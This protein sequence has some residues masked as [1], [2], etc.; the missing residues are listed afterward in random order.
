MTNAVSGEK[1]NVE[2]IVYNGTAKN[3][4]AYND[5]ATAP[6]E[7]SEGK[8][9][10][11]A[12]KLSDENYTVKGTAAHKFSVA[13][14]EVSITYDLSKSPYTYDAASHIPAWEVVGL[15]EGDT[16][17]VSDYTLSGK[18]VFD[19]D[20]SKATGAVNATKD[21]SAVIVTVTAIGNGNYKLPTSA[22]CK[23]E[24]KIVPLNLEDLKVGT[25]DNHAAEA[26]SNIW[27]AKMGYTG[28][29]Q[30]P[31][32]M[33]DSAAGEKE[34][35]NEKPNRTKYESYQDEQKN[36]LV[37]GYNASSQTEALSYSNKTLSIDDKLKG[38]EIEITGINN[39]KGTTKIPWNIDILESSIEI[40]NYEAAGTKP[41]TVTYGETLPEIEFSYK[42]EDIEKDSEKE[43]EDYVTYT[44]TGTMKN[45]KKYGE[46][47]EEKHT[48]PVE[49]GEYEVTATLAATDH[50]KEVAAT[51]KFIIA[52]KEVTIRSGVAVYDKEYDGTDE[53]QLNFTGFDDDSWEGLLDKD[54]ET[55]KT[56]LANVA[57]GDKGYITYTAKFAE[58]SSTNT[59]AKDV[60]WG[61]N[62]SYQKVVED[63]TVEISGYAIDYSKEDTPDVLYNYVIANNGNPATGKAKITPKQISVSG[64]TAKD[65]VY[66]GSRDVELIIP[67]SEKMIKGLVG[68]EKLSLN[69]TGKFADAPGVE[70]E[71]VVL[72]DGKPA[73]KEVT[74][75]Y[76]NDSIIAGDTSTKAAN[77]KLKVKTDTDGKIITDDKGNEVIDDTAVQ[78]TTNATITPATITI[79]GVKAAEKTYDGTPNVTLIWDD[80]SVSITGVCSG[81]VIELDN[82]VNNGTNGWTADSFNDAGVARNKYDEV[83]D[84]E[85]TITS[86]E[87]D[88]IAKNGL[89]GTFNPADYKVADISFT[90]KIN[91]KKISGITWSYDKDSFSDLAE[92][93]KLLC[94]TSYTVDKKNLEQ[95]PKAAFE[96]GSGVLAGDSCEPVVKYYTA[97][98][99]EFA[100]PLNEVEIQIEENSEKT[101]T[102][103]YTPLPYLEDNGKYVVKVVSTTNPNYVVD[104]TAS[105]ITKSFTY[106]SNADSSELAITNY[107]KE[108]NKSFTVTYGDPLPKVE[109]S[110]NNSDI[111]K[112]DAAAR[113]AH[114]TYRYTGKALNGENYDSDKAPVN[115]GS[116]EVTVALEA[117]EHFAASEDSAAFIIEPR[118]VTI[119]QGISVKDKIYN[120]TDKATLD[121][122]NI[123]FDNIIEA[124]KETVS[125]LFADAKEDYIRYSAQFPQKDVKYMETV[126]DDNGGTGRKIAEM[127]VTA[128]N[129]SFIQAETTP[130][131]LYN[132][133]IARE[134][135]IGSLYGKIKPRPVTV[136]GIRADDKTFDGTDNLSLN[137]SEMKF[138]GHIKGDALK[139][140]VKGKIA[141]T[142]GVPARDVLIGKD[143]KPGEKKVLLTI[144]DLTAG[145]NTTNVDNY[146]LADKGQQTET[147]VKI[148]PAELTSAKWSF[149]TGK[150][151]PTAVIDKDSGLITTGSA[152]TVQ[153]KYYEASDMSYKKPITV[154][155]LKAG[156][157]YV[158]RIEGYSDTNYQMSKKF[159]NPIYP[160][161][162]GKKTETAAEKK[163]VAKKKK[164]IINLKTVT[165]KKNQMKIRWT[166]VSSADGYDVYVKYCTS[167]S[168][169]IKPVKTVKNNRKTFVTVKKIN[170]KKLN[171][172]KN[173]TIYVR[174]YRKVG[175]KKKILAKS[176]SGHVAGYRNQKYSNV[177]KVTLLK[178]RYTIK[179]GK[180]ARIK[181][182][183]TLLKKNRKHLPK[184][185]GAR[186]RYKS[187]DTS[188]AT[189]NRS[190]RI[191]GVKK[192]TCT[193]YVY[194]I[195]GFAKKVRVTVK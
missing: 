26:G 59:A 93:A 43:P 23:A 163:T 86:A 129:Y 172:K 100:N 125:T 139:V 180:T 164:I 32:I 22:D 35:K 34:L 72:D 95:I 147:T 133:S 98:D 14:K 91:P 5:S 155:E 20:Y 190:G 42:N 41:Y 67:E 181:A 152:G 90:G 88:I 50:Y 68:K 63:K 1:V 184:S 166:R 24:Y 103:V 27:A 73:A 189:V 153:L 170:G 79:H 74:L 92:G 53:A 161:V 156:G 16:C 66:N 111:E 33:W 82:T 183:V 84:K 151:L 162:Y 60:K 101:R 128:G 17:E 36:A 65:K 167:K 188:I 191:K 165:Q 119:L 40:T 144:S 195:N 150:N 48:A 157:S 109:L 137:L 114:F 38:Y 44:Y 15:V 138:T 28:A 113:A 4:T 104:E 76:D 75:I 81:D 130:A 96:S 64:I 25:W 122:R 175:G 179:T 193:I 106:D 12:T 69:I 10:V 83:I 30:E 71:D 176:V 105:D 80:Q 58:D 116:Y 37:R 149:D 99:K 31:K 115:A 194:S 177:K 146:Y 160:F 131:V 185:H 159:R 182:K 6:K 154:K 168:S 61:R 117:T 134:N 97:A 124:D 2:E 78:Q 169:H 85:G 47:E 54:K 102:G 127:S 108:N 62:A 174:A 52:Q 49:A 77:Y 3:G 118:S 173:F 187:S 45:G 9:S 87:Y 145:D 148:T 140:S 135:T 120:G 94:S 121:F 89:K 56:A 110:Y 186:F 7:A 107:Q 55:V 123:V 136:S 132:Y 19:A 143:G 46:T 112:E 141:D 8:Y 126:A 57:K 158:A 70:P 21:G 13:Q 51:K 142:N 192:G 18:D 39:F 178:S 171:L 29:L 11:K